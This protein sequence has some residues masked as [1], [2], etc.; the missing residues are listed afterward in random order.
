[1][2]TG[3]TFTIAAISAL[4]GSSVLSGAHL[5]F[6][7]FGYQPPEQCVE[8]YD[9]CNMCDKAENGKAICTERSCT[10]HGKGFCRDYATST[11][12]TQ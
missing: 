12:Q 3:I 4:G 2:K 6:S 5:T 7:P 8:W 11:S 10:A 1:M 9:G